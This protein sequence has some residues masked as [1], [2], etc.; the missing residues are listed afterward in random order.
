MTVAPA[1]PE[2]DQHRLE[3]IRLLER[4]VDGLIRYRQQQERVLALA[5]LCLAQ[6]TGQH[7]DNLLHALNELNQATNEVAA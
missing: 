4:R 3:R 1:R 2:V 7:A 5:V 6:L